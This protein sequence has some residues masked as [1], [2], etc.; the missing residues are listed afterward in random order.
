MIPKTLEVMNADGT[1]HTVLLSAPGATIDAPVFSPD[2]K[3]IAFSNAA[4]NGD[5][6]IFVRNADGS[7]DRLTY[8][9][10]TDLSPSW[11]PDGSR[12]AFTSTRNGKLQIWTMSSSG[13]SAT[14]ISRNAYAERTPAY[15]H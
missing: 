3:R 7:V 4:A 9:A 8:A 14:R 1:G 10:G 13:G 6:E 15:S 2:G 12:I 5:Q 11:S